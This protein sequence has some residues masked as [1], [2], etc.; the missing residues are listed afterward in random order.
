MDMSFLNA[1][2]ESTL[3]RLLFQLLDRQGDVLRPGFE[4]S[5]GIDKGPT[6]SSSLFETLIQQAAQ[7]YGVDPALVRSVIRAESNFNPQAVSRAG[8][9]GLMQL[10]PGTARSLGVTDPFDP[11]QNIDG[12]VRLLR[13]LL[14]RYDGNVALALAAYN[15]GPGAVDRFQGIPP[16]RETQVYVDRVLDYYRQES[17][18]SA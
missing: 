8:A 14:D 1:A 18:W 4:V 12:G 17:G 16:Y 13:R 10:M 7:R 15:A 9:M 3:Y 11:S 2:F 6:G 5:E